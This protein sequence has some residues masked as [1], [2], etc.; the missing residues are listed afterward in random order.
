VFKGFRCP[1]GKGDISFADC[2][3]HSRSDPPECGFVYPILAGIVNNLR[4]EMAEITATQLLNC[5]R[6]VVLERRHDVHIEPQQLYYSFRGQMFHQIASG[7]DLNECVVE[8]R[9]K[10]EVAGITLSGQPDLIVPRLGKLYD[11]KT[12][13]RI[14]KEGQL[15][16]QHGLQ[17]NI[18]R[19]LVLPHY[20][21]DHLEVVYMDMS[22]VRRATV[23]VM[24]TRKLMGWL[25]PRVKKLKAALE[26]GRLPA[27]V[28]SDGL[29]QC[30]G[31]C[32]FT[33]RC[34]PKGAPTPAELKR[35]EE[36][37]RDAV[38]RAVKRKRSAE[39]AAV[40]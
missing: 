14:P 17:V 19:W 30:R 9:F 4:G 2:L 1:Y 15:Y 10:R 28:G 18:Y 32:S 11:F 23:E 6:K 5:L 33:E 26:G 27:R 7:V 20:P 29:W 12:T 40:A 24:N 35:K 39:A 8:Q 38:L 22:E 16:A 25:V 34:W 37:A 36:A 21:I 13:R 31:Y 3:E